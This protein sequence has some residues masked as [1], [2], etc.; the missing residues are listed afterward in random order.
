[1]RKR[2]RERES[3][4]DS[5]SDCGCDSDSEGEQVAFLLLSVFILFLQVVLDQVGNN[6]RLRPG[7][8]SP[9][10]AASHTAGAFVASICDH[11]Q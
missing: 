5:D 2:E 11:T 4:S 7:T 1:M 10:R 9:V 8:S 3:D 6:V